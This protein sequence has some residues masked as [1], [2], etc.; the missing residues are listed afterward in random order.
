MNLA[1]LCVA[2]LVLT[3]AGCAAVR[4]PVRVH[5]ID[6]QKPSFI[7]VDASRRGVIVV[8][9]PDGKGWI[10][11]SEPSPD[12]A[13][14]TVTR[15]LGE[16]KVN[17]PNVPVDAK[18]EMEF[19][20]AVVELSKRTQTILF[21]REA[22]FRICEQSI[23]QNLSADQ[24]MKLYELAVTTALKMAEADVAK[25]QADLAKQLSDPKVRE[26]WKSVIGEA[27]ATRK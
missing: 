3:L 21:L 17:N 12:V 10:V 15:I 23:N 11:C 1:T 16:V 19:R 25:N 9:R 26:L 13:L 4:A 22:M 2:G 20:T 14:E 24:V 7:E 5:P 6:P 8:P 27:P 18:T